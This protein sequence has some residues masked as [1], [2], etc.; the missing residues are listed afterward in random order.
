[1]ENRYRANFT[2]AFVGMACHDLSG[3]GKHADFDY[4]EYVEIT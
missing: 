2:G 1:M 3:Q 4:F